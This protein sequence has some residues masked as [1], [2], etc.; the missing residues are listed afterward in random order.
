VILNERSPTL[1]SSWST[2]SGPVHGELHI[3]TEKRGCLRH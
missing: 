3:V 1:I 2:V